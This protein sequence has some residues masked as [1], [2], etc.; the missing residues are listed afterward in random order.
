M[1]VEYVMGNFLK[2]DMQGFA[3]RQIVSM[4]SYDKLL[5]ELGKVARAQRF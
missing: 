3:Q 2:F 4:S 5:I 1:V